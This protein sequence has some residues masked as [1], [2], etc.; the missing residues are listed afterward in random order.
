MNGIYL[1]TVIR[2]TAS[3]IDDE[4]RVVRDVNLVASVIFSVDLE[5]DGLRATGD[6]GSLVGLTLISKVGSRLPVLDSV[7][8]LAGLELPLPMDRIISASKFSTVFRRTI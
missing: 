5:F 1:Y 6:K 7:A 8:V 3:K 4:V 2:S